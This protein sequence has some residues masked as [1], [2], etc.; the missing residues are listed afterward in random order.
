MGLC[1]NSVMLTCGV[2]VRNLRV[3]DAFEARE[4]QD[5]RRMAAGLGPRPRRRRRKT[6]VDL[7]DATTAPP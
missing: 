3:I 1:A 5:R 7:V 2:V 4:A 6:L